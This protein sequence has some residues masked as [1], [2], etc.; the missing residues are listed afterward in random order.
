[1]IEVEQDLN[2]ST[3]CSFLKKEIPE[4]D[5]PHENKSRV[6][7][8][9]ELQIVKKK[10]VNLKR[11][12]GF[13][14]LQGSFRRLILEAFLLLTVSRVLILFVPFKKLAGYMGKANTTSAK[15]I[16]DQGEKFAREA[17]RAIKKASLYTP[18][19]SMCFEQALTAKFMFNRRKIDTTIYFGVAKED[20]VGLK[21]HAWTRAG[22]YYVTGNKGKDLFT[23]IA[24]FA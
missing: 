15:S 6:K 11:L 2:W 1:V 8:I 24:T 16:N 20:T 18:F 5:F 4:A 7:D 12:M 14:A 3:L 17:G 10:Q 23:E 9:G 19:R 22:H 13:F 21:A